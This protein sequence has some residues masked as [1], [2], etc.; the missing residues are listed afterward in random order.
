MRSAPASLNYLSRCAGTFSEAEQAELR[1][2]GSSIASYKC[3][4]K[5]FMGACQMSVKNDIYAFFE[6]I[7][8]ILFQVSIL[9]FSRP[10]LLLLPLRLLPPR[11]L[12]LRLL[13]LRL[14]P[15]R[16]LPLLLLPL[17]LLHLEDKIPAGD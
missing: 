2:M 10:R 5:I 13:P 14:L 15:L 12:L 8:F 1:E 16:L 3:F 11:L 4:K 6:V 7:L 17:L 9:I